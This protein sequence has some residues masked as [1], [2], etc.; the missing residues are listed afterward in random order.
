MFTWFEVFSVV[1]LTVEVMILFLTFIS[2]HL[3]R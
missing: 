1:L 2:D 3:R